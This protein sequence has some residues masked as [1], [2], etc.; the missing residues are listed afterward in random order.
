MGTRVGWDIALASLLLSFATSMVVATVYTITY[1]GIGYL[2][3]FVQTIALGG[4]VAALVMLAIGDD[5][6]RGLGMVGALTLIRFRTT[7][8]DTRDLIFMFAS[9][10]IGVA[11]GVQAFA[12]ALL[13]TAMFSL[14]AMYLSWSEFGSRLQFDIMLRFQGPADAEHAEQ[15][16]AV[17]HRYCRGLSLIDLRSAGDNVQEFAYHLKLSKPNTETALIRDLERVP[18]VGSAAM[19]TRDASLEL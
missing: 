1:H 7:L 9:L 8:K 11:C 3:S 6:A 14:A 2:K 18:G 15:V 13:G 19:F 16:R 17:L 4:L 10:G 5:V 12:A